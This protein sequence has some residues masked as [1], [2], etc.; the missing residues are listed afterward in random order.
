MR[1]R[2]LLLSLSIAFLL[3]GCMKDE[4]DI[5]FNDDSEVESQ[6]NSLVEGADYKWSTNNYTNVSKALSDKSYIH[7][8]QETRTT[9]YEDYYNYI[10]YNVEID[11]VSKLAYITKCSGNSISDGFT[12]EKY[13]YSWGRENEGIYKNEYNEWVSCEIEDKGTLGFLK[14]AKNMENLL[15][16]L[17]NISQLNADVIS[18]HQA[19]SV[20]EVVFDKA[21]ETSGFTTFYIDL[22]TNLP[23]YCTEDFDS[24]STYIAI[25]NISNERLN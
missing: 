23:I 9:T 4:I 14:N 25:E 19:N 1:K 7:F 12:Q 16:L 3:S 13:K 22:N 24:F 2:L 8:T 5:T 17:F 6:T 15:D 11:L 20:C 10:N 18:K 21:D